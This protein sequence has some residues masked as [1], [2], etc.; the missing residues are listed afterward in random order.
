MLNSIKRT[1]GVFSVP[2]HQNGWFLIG[3]SLVRMRVESNNVRGCFRAAHSNRMG[4]NKRL[5]LVLTLLVGWAI[6]SQA[7]TLAVKKQI[8]AKLI[9]LKSN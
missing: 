9:A 1:A 7:Q 4:T 6:S 2:L 8:V 3:E 5:L